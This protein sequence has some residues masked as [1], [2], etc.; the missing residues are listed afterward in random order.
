LAIQRRSFFLWDKYP[1]FLTL[2]PFPFSLI[3]YLLI[4]LSLSLILSL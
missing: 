2:M 4:L 3:L 1:V